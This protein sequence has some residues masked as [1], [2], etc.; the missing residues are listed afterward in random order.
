MEIPVACTGGGH[1]DFV[2]ARNFLNFWEGDVKGNIAAIKR[3]NII[4]I[5]NLMSG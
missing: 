1:A 2:S 4:L 3:A 5:G